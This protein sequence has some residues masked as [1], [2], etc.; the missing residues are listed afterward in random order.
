MRLGLPLSNPR[1][2]FRRNPGVALARKAGFAATNYVDDL[3]EDHA[4]FAVLL[5]E[6]DVLDAGALEAFVDDLHRHIAVE[7]YDLFPV[8]AQLVADADW[9]LIGAS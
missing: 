6:V 9:E 3:E 2:Q 8:A 1:R 4:R 7:E 5:D